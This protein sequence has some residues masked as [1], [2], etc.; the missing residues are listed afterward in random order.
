[1]RPVCAN[2]GPGCR[3]RTSVKI[4]TF[5]INGI[6]RRLPNL[7]AW[8]QAAKPDVACL[9]E[10]KAAHADFPRDAIR[11][12]GYEAVWQG[13]RS[14]NGVAI[15]ARGREPVPTR[16]SLPGGPHD[17]QARYLEA[18]VDG[19]LIAC[20][21]LPNGNPQPGPKFDYK[22][23]WFERLIIHA[24]ELHATGLPVVLAGDYNVVPTD[25]DI[26]PSKSWG[27]NALL[28]PVVREAFARLLAQG[29]TDALRTIHPAGPLPSFWD[30]MRD[31]FS[32]DAGL[33]LDHILLS[34]D[35]AGRLT[36]A[37]VDRSVRGEQNASDH[38]PAWA[39]VSNKRAR[40]GRPLAPFPDHDQH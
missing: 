22:L 26:Y 34:P 36:D 38:A 10:L 31:G 25:A 8:L 37:G 35:L 27:R 11:E 40:N 9:Q 23:A 30:Y 7:L 3:V 18:A 4:A 39:S 21:Y 24:A 32:R 14:W 15:L 2:P 20:L 5:N 17:D 12:A 13:E 16:R 1:M 19:V 6:N 33:R 28:Q 29:W